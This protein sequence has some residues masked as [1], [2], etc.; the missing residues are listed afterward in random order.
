[1]IF[2]GDYINKGPQ[3][4]EVMEELVALARAGICQVN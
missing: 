3:S 4:A 1:M 2:L